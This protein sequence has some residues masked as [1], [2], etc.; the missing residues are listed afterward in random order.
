[1]KTADAAHDAACSAQ[2]APVA[3]E[4]VLAFYSYSFKHYYCGANSRKSC[5]FRP[6]RCAFH[7]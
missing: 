3:D 2:V 7:I 1:V 6:A 4:Y 5:P